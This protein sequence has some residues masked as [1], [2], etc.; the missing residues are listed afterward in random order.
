[1]SEIKCDKCEHRSLTFDTFMDLSLPIPKSSKS[2]PSAGYS[3]LSSSSY[4]SEGSVSLIDCLNEFSKPEELDTDYKCEKCKKAGRITK[5]TSIYYLPKVLVLHLKWFS[6]SSHSHKKIS[7]SVTFP[8]S[9]LNL[10]DYCATKQSEYNLFGISH[11]SGY[12]GG[13]HYVADI[14]NSDGKW[15]HC[16]D[17]HASAS[18]SP[19]SG[20][21][22]SPYLLFY[23]R[24]DITAKL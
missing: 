12:M 18:Y 5:K 20:S 19:P 3:Y 17:S 1:M 21:G 10:S 24:N 9:G 13:G 15:Y 6:Y 2:T 11:H 14:L 16:D 22:S 7:T 8:I 23:G 4:G